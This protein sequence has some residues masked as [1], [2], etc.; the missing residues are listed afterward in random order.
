[1]VGCSTMPDEGYRPVPSD[2]GKA[3]APPTGRLKLVGMVVLVAAIAAAAWGIVSRRATEASLAKWTDQQAIATVAVQTP[4]RDEAPRTLRLPGDVQAFYEAPIYARVNGYLQTWSQ[5]IGAHVK[6]GQILG[7]IDAP[8]LDQELIQ[9]QADLATAKA[10]S[11]L[12]DLTAKR[13]RALLASNSVSQQSVDEKE[14]NALA[15]RAIVNA[16][17]AHVERLRAT[18][19]FKRLVA[20]FNGIVTARNTDVG[21]LI[22][23]GPGEAHPL[24]RVA[25]VHEMRV[26][27]SVPQA[28]ASQ[29]KAGLHAT[30][31]QP[32]YPGVKFPAQLATTSQ[33]VTS[34]SRTVLTELMAPNPQGQLW[35]GTYAEVT[36]ELPGDATVLRV[37]ASALIFRAQGAQIATVAADNRIVLKK[38]AIGRNLGSEIEIIDGLSPQDRIVVSPLDTI[39][40]GEAVDIASPGAPISSPAQPEN[41]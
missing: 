14:G 40:E 1:M 8:E 31:T 20:P 35:P 29:L 17:T 13:W 26:Y 28:Y 11:A 10:N 41:E 2:I 9:A 5:D 12:A 25:D 23:A 6:A 4:T 18:S 3:P 30:L 36:F 27:V 16:Q 37:P 15:Q 39:S 7:T 19:G 24:F 32:Q 33:S 34:D 22:N 21:A 38:V